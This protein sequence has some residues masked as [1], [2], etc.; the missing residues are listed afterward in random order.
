LGQ[1]YSTQ[2]SLR[3]LVSDSLVS[4]DR[5]G[6]K[7]TFVMLFSLISS[8]L[9]VLIFLY[10][11]SSNQYILLAIS[12]GLLLSSLLILTKILDRFY[13]SPKEEAL[14]RA[15][16][17]ERLISVA[18]QNSSEY[19]DRIFDTVAGAIIST[20]LN[21]EIITFNDSA[22]SIFGY[23]RDEVLG[24]NISLL[25]P[26]ASVNKF[27]S[28][29][30]NYL[31][32]P[33][34][35]IFG[36][37]KRIQAV[38]KNGKEFPAHIDINTVDNRNGAY[39]VLLIVDESKSL[40][41]EKK[42][43]KT[44]SI[45]EVT[46]NASN[47]AILV[48]NNAGI[49]IICNQNFKTMWGINEDL[50]EGDSVRNEILNLVRNKKENKE[51]LENLDSANESALE[52]VELIDNR[53]I[54]I[55]SEYKMLGN[56]VEVRIWSYRD[57]TDQLEYES[58]LHEA[59]EKAEAGTAAKSNFLASMSHEIRTPMNG[60]LGML[61][62]L[63][64]SEL[65]AAQYRKAES[66]KQSAES[67]MSLLNDML[68]FS[69]MEANKLDLEILDFNLRHHLDDLAKNFSMQAK[70]K[71]LEIV[72]DASD[73][74][75]SMVR[76]DPTRLR[77]ILSNLVGNAIKFSSSGEVRILA[78]LVKSG[79]YGL[80]LFCDVKDAG[81]G[82]PNSKRDKLFNVF[83]QV[84]SSASRDYE[85][86]G[87]G[88]AICKQLTTLMG[89]DVTF[90]SELGMGSCFSF[91]IMLQTSN[92]SQLSL[93]IL[94]LKNALILLV[95]NDEM[96]LEIM[97]AQLVLWG[98]EVVTAST[99]SVAIS[100]LENRQRASEQSVDIAFIDMRMPD[101]DGAQLGRIIRQ[102]KH[103]DDMKMVMMTSMSARG[104]AKYYA[105]I[106]FNAYLPKPITTS[107]MFDALSVLV[108][109]DQV[110]LTAKPLVTS[111]YLKELARSE[112][113]E[114]TNQTPAKLGIDL[115]LLL[116]EDNHLNVVVVAEILRELGLSADIARNGVEALEA[117]ENS[118]NSYD[119]LLMDCQM[120]EMNGYEATVLIRDGKAGERYRHV[121]VIALTAHAMAEDKDKCLASGMND[122]LSKPLEADL[123]RSKLIQWSPKADHLDQMWKK[124]NKIASMHDAVLWDEADVLKR[125]RGK[126]D[127]LK[128]LVNMCLETLPEHMEALE[129]SAKSLDMAAARDKAHLIKGV[130]ANISGQQ[131]MACM[132]VCEQACI[133]E[134]ADR[135]MKLLPNCHEQFEN[136]SSRLRRYLGS[137]G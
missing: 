18:S 98:A 111:H 92:Q 6:H 128:H 16:A 81:I 22:N 42:I 64:S 59:K 132:A 41:I 26:S 19:V 93:P 112:F 65:S 48:T 2:Q 109:G 58:K 106:G 28:K 126:E 94:D 45:L 51:K 62:L 29:I 89:G 34:E 104:D 113:E 50:A 129:V 84:D 24:K 8:I 49:V 10:L 66:A 117:L 127:R 68:D 70:E 54:E 115:Q 86:T 76:G 43:E 37:E 38:S 120:P 60:I 99:G 21:G 95:D 88:L 14:R 133:D 39:F 119:V 35:E 135:V 80:Q 11:P 36:K 13:Y 69:K 131:L 63:L 122:Y 85:G 125:M 137:E 32:S 27:G 79:S 78:R 130:A 67:L 40:S 7:N 3:K 121:P 17:E 103:F 75:H 12:N 55:S 77:Q 136:L 101:T 134:D 102:R 25:I 90:V 108:R 114:I 20:G 91:N 72:L 118:E 87:L 123:L 73:V 116:V 110:L 56:E 15:L 5:G 31:V 124:E 71:G 1:E 74:E 83:T 30:D 53:K 96:N 23:T 9:F 82:I 105:N 100:L 107:D 4:V 52:L 61:G 44:L 97:S 47:N 46:V 57:L 33:R